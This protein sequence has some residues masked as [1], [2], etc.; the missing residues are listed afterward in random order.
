M[1]HQEGAFRPARNTTES[2]PD[3]DEGEILDDGDQD[4]SFVPSFRPP[5]LVYKPNTPSNTPSQQ[6]SLQYSQQQSEGSSARSGRGKDVAT[7]LK[8]QSKLPYPF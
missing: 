6:S 3:E 2:E 7:L 1:Q 4:N 5:P 8:L